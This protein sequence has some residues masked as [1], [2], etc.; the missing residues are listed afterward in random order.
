MNVHKDILESNVKL[1]QFYLLGNVFCYFLV[2]APTWRQ[3]AITFSR[4]GVIHD[5]RFN[6]FNRIG[7]RL[8]QRACK[9]FQ[10]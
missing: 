4:W 3:N 7:S 2:I 6:K 9:R 10:S 1:N 5:R 8:S